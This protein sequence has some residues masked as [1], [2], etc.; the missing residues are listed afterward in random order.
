M[1]VK[2]VRDKLPSVGDYPKRSVEDVTHIDIHH[3]ASSKNDYKGEET[4]NIFAKFH[5]N[6][7]GWP[8]IGY[9][10]IVAPNGD[11]FKTGYINEKRWSVAGNNSYTISVM[12]IGN[13]EKEELESKQYNAALNLIEDIMDAYDI[14]IKNV[15]GHKEYKGNE[16]KSCPGFNMDKVRD[17]LYKRRR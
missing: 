2:D 17:D 10:Y 3:S 1:N 6:N 11:I 12:L 8:G 13:F 7:N 14:S 9:H 15:K 4:I 5:I 16:K